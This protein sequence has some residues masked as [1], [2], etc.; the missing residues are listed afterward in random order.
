V[1]RVWVVGCKDLGEEPRAGGTEQACGSW[2]SVGS[3]WD[4]PWAGRETGSDL[5]GVQ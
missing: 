1:R 5:E 3:P 4:R 2:G